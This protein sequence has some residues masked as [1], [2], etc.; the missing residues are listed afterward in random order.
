MIDDH[1]IELHHQMQ[2]TRNNCFRDGKSNTI[3]HQMKTGT[4]GIITFFRQE[5]F[6][7]DYV[8]LQKQS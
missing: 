8:I 2:E 1:F 4:K 6:A 7:S 3:L 5:F